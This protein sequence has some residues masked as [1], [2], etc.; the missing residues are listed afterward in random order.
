M[1]NN[2]AIIVRINKLEPLIFKDKE[3]NDI[4][5]DNIQLAK[6]FGTQ[7]IV[8]KKVKEGDIMCYVDS[9]MRLLPDFLKENN[10][11]RHSEFNKDT[12][13]SGFFEDNGRVKCIR[14]KGHVSDGFLFPVDYLNF[15]GKNF[16]ETEFI[17]NTIE[18]TEVDGIKICEKYVPPRQKQKGMGNRANSGRKAPS[19][20]MFVEHYDTGQFFRNQHI[21]PPQTICYIEEKIHGTSHRTGHVQII[22][23]PKGLKKLL[24]K[25]LL[26][27]SLKKKYMYLNGTRR[28]VHIPRK[29]INSYHNNTMREEVLEKTRGL[30]LKG[31]QIYLELFGFDTNGGAIQGGFP[32][33][34]EPGEYRSCLYRVTM[35]NEDGK[36]VDYPREYVYKRAEE[37][38][39]EKPYLFEKYYYSGT[40][41]SM[42][43]LE[44]KVIDYAQGQSALASNTVREGVVVWF[45][46]EQGQ[47]TCLKYKS[48]TFRN[49][50]SSKI[51]KGEIDQENFN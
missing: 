31:E 29:E 10:L 42:E 7:V 24:L 36:V 25:L 26:K 6:L 28:V 30:L 17:N 40:K 51:D 47:W 13:K 35:N 11:Y 37:L 43:K 5:A 14:I 38:G 8:S 4:E 21:I 34:C 3:G 27:T 48:D 44:K 22:E 12:S 16:S 50:E 2:T 33:G 41:R 23:K 15:A 18:F 20:P 19:S 1:N 46:T 9:N 32:Y 39:F 45:I 49:L